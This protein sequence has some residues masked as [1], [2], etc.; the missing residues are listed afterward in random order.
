MERLSRVF[1]HLYKFGVMEILTKG[2]GNQSILVEKG[3]LHQMIL[4]FG[5]V[6]IFI[7][8]YFDSI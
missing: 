5:Y 6:F 3:K 2:S 1:Y 4:P 8:L 7:F